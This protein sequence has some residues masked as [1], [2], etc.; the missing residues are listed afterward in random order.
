MKK[1]LSYAG[2]SERVNNSRR[3]QTSTFQNE[4]SLFR[5]YGNVTEIQIS[6]LWR[7]D[8][9]FENCSFAEIRNSLRIEFWFGGNIHGPQLSIF[10]PYGVLDFGFQFTNIQTLVFN[11]FDNKYSL[12]IGN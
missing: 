12:L 1:Y 11:S 9:N 8:W 5:K 7:L 2:T 10:L 3:F 6:K 4:N